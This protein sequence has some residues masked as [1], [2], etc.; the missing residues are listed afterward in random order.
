MRFGL[1]RPRSA[2]AGCELCE[3][4]GCRAASVLATRVGTSIEQNLH[5]CRASIPHRAV[6]RRHAAHV[7]S[8]RICASVNQCADGRRLRWRIPMGRARPSI[9]RVVQ[10]LLTPP[11][12]GVNG[13]AR[14]HQLANKRRAVRCCRNVQRR[15]TFVHVVFDPVDE[16]T[17][18]HLARGADCELFADQL[19]M[20]LDELR[21]GAGIRRDHTKQLGK[22]DFALR[23]SSGHAVDNYALSSRSQ[24][25]RCVTSRLP[26]CSDRV[27]CGDSCNCHRMS[28]ATATTGR[29]AR[30]SPLWNFN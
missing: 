30:R 20:C 22:R 21:R 25:H 11:I 18:R 16:V 2:S 5:R 27:T 23:A 6:Q 1:G 12:R 15:V 8:V 29:R 28:P 17:R 24:P 14:G 19:G 26:G 9:Y 4:R 3:L 13:G 10:R 7:D